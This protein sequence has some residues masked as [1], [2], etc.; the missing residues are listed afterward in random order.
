M[1]G[2]QVIIILTT[3]YTAFVIDGVPVQGSGLREFNVLTPVDLYMDYLTAED[4]KGIEIMR[5]TPVCYCCDNPDITY[6]LTLYAD[7]IRSFIPR[8]NHLFG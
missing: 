7:R 6:L 4:I 2:T 8:N 3:G 5:Y 1:L